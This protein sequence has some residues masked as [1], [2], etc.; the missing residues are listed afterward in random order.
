MAKKKS[1]TN[2]TAISPREHIA[3]LVN[4][5]AQGV[6]EKEQIIAMALLCA[7]AG[8]NIFLLGPPGTAKSLV[9]ARLKG[10]FK[11]A[12][13]FDYL[14]SRFSTPDEIF[15]PISISRL[16]NEDKYERLVDGYLPTADVVFLDE[17]WKA[18]PS[19]QNTLLTA[20]NEHLYH[21]GSE[22][23]HIPMKVLIAASNELPAKDE[24]L[25]ALWDRFLVRMVSNCIESEASFLKMIR[26]EKMELKPLDDGLPIDTDLYSKWQSEASLIDMSAEVCDAIKA[27]RKAI[28]AK[29]K[30]DGNTLLYYVSDRRWKKAYRLLSGSAYFNGRSAIDLTDFLLLIH[31]FWNDVECRETAINMVLGSMFEV[32]NRK[33]IN[34]DRTVR[35]IIKPTEQKPVKAAPP[36][37]DSLPFAE[38]NYFYYKIDNYPEGECFFSKWDYSTLDSSKQTEGIQYLDTTRNTLIIHAILPG[39]PFDNKPRGGSNIKKVRIQ[40]CNGGIYINGTPYAFV[41][42]HGATAS[43]PPQPQSIMSRIYDVQ[44]QFRD[45]ISRWKTIADN[46]WKSNI[47]LSQSDIALVTGKM[48]EVENLV[49]ET[50]VKIK[51]LTLLL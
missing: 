34:I 35:Q 46:D 37:T 51:N 31:C 23:L 15:G 43:A 41:K 20:I 49:N 27:L 14:M 39:R 1:T 19:I 12:R 3:K 25:E 26:G 11:D 48:Q 13:S 47:F 18:G 9:A 24:G 36:Q 5:M 33:L 32:I 21:N 16:K 42:K 7:V 4:W 17:I 44:Q 2:P 40:K 6:Y 45:C 8:E 28:N 22:T 29:E 38:Y 50:D 10:I 30:E